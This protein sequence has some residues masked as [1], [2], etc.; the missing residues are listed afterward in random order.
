MCSISS[1]STLVRR[2]IDVILEILVKLSASSSASVAL[3]ASEVATLLLLR[4]FVG[5][6]SVEYA[7]IVERAR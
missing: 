5:P 7:A 4:T 6:S 1:S 2:L 3:P